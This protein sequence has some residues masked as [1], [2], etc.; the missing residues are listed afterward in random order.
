[1]N[2]HEYQ[3][4]EIL[5][6]FNIPVPKGFV[7]FLVSDIEKLNDNLKDVLNNKQ[8]RN[9]LIKNGTKSSNQYL[10]YQNNSSSKLIGFLEELMN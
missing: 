2:I 8:V 9:Q 6:K 1:M 7:A 3:A 4:K 5:R 10:S